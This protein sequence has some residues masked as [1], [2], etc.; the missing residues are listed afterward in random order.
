[1]LWNHDWPDFGAFIPGKETA[2]LSGWQ[3]ENAAV[4]KIS[5]IKVGRFSGFFPRH[6]QETG[7]EGF[8]QA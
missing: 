8:V 6:W 5:K 2:Q 7:G 1:M 4:G 3:G